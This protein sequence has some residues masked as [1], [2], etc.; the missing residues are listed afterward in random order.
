[1]SQLTQKYT[2]VCFLEP[3]N[4]PANFSAVDWPLHVT[5]LDTFK[6]SWAV[7][8]LS[9]A[10]RETV[11][12]IASFNIKPVKQAMLGPNKDVPV[13]LLKQDES[14]LNLHSRLLA[15]SEEGSFVFNTPDFVGDGFLPH[16]TDQRDGQVE[17]GEIYPVTTVSLVDMFPNG[18]GHQR[19]LIKTI[20]I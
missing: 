12:N 8:E 4:A 10:I 13:K 9:R 7:E 5:M 2:I 19:R 16:V 15:L 6:T 3:E 1:M 20:K 17:V 11:S 14:I 18:D